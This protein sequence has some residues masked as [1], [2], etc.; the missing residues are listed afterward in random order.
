MASTEDIRG[1]YVKV[2]GTRVFYDEIGEGCPIVCVHTAG[3]CLLGHF[4]RDPTD[5]HDVRMHHSQ[6]VESGT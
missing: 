6:V 4:S 2:N 1:R 3:A 5:V